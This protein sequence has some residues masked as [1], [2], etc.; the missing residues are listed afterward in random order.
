MGPGLRLSW[1]GEKESDSPKLRLNR[2][3]WL[4]VVPFEDTSFLIFALDTA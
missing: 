1:E 3:L 4:C 2:D